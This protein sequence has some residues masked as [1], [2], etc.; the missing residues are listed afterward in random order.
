M[1]YFQLEPIYR[2]ESKPTTGINFRLFPIGIYLDKSEWMEGILNWRE[3]NFEMI[4]EDD[5][6]QGFLADASE[7]ALRITGRSARSELIAGR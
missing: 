5:R 3:E 6:F 7:R 2:G 1:D 4:R